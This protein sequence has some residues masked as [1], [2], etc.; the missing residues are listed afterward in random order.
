[1]KGILG[2]TGYYVRKKAEA[3]CINPD[4]YEFFHIDKIC[5]CKE[6]DWECDAGFRK[7][8]DEDESHTCV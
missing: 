6:D 3:K 8:G 5:K 1:M 4:H 2:K 7:S